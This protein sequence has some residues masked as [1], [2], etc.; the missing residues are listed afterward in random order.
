MGLSQLQAELT[1]LRNYFNGKKTELE[2]AVAAAVAAAPTTERN[3]YVDAVDGLDTNPGTSAAPFKTV[4]RA[5]VLTAS[6]LLTYIWLRAAQVHQMVND[7]ELR[8]S[9]VRF[10]RWGDVGANPVLTPLVTAGNGVD[11]VSRCIGLSASNVLLSQVDLT[12]APKVDAGLPWRGF[13]GFFVVFARD[14][15]AGS[16]VKM[17]GSNGAPLTRAKLT[18]VPGQG[19][20]RSMSGL[21]GISLSGV[22]TINAGDAGTTAHVALGSGFNGP[23]S[24][25]I[26]DL[27][28][29]AGTK[30]T[31]SVAS[32]PDGYKSLITNYTAASGLI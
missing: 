3:L 19:L 10:R 24:I 22:E 6:G 23:L 27:L 4:D 5:L 30:L 31:D 29:G 32:H 12:M 11:N 14:S 20:V 9:A 7:H 2:A 18:L 21:E 28:L 8:Y 15:L 26:Y 1:S 13:N 16:F 25:G 17:S